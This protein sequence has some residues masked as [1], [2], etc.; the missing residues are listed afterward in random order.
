MTFWPAMPLPL[1]P[2]RRDLAEVEVHRLLALGVGA[3]PGLAVRPPADE[4]GGVPEPRPLHVVV[5]DLDHPLRPQ[6]DERQVLLRVPPAGL[7]VARCPS[8]RLLPG[9]VP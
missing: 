2:R 7:G 4:L 8:T 9:P 1:R 3:R 5:P 6:R